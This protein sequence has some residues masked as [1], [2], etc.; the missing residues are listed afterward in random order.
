VLND[1]KRAVV[2]NAA[3]PP[4]IDGTWLG[5][6]GEV[7]LKRQG[8]NHYSGESEDSNQIAHRGKYDPKR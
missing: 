2:H 6:G 3:V 1:R 4:F 8:G 7:N 5:A